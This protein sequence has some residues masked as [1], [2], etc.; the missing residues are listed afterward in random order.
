MKN[1]VLFFGPYP[2]PLFGQSISF[3][4]AYLNSIDA[5]ILFDTTK[6]GELKFLNTLYCIVF[7]PLIFFTRS[8]DKVYFTCSR[9]KLGFIKDLQL[10]VLSRLF[11]KK[12]INHLHGADFLEFYHSATYFKRLIYWAYNQIDTSIVLLPSMTDQFVDFKDMKI[13]VINNCYA[14]EY[15]DKKVDFKNKRNE[16]VFLSNLIFSKGIFIFLEAVREILKRDDEVIVKV[17]GSPMGDSLMSAHQLKTKFEKY[18]NELRNDFPNRFF[19][20]S[21]VRGRQKEE[22]LKQS[23]IFILPTFYK[24]E[25][26]PLT[27]IEAM[28]FG[29]AII[30][31][32]HNYLK[33]IVQEENGFLTQPKSV[34]ELIRATLYLLK[35]KN[36]CGKIQKKNHSEAKKKYNPNIFDHKLKKAISNT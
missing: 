22:L 26:F 12:V 8:F 29:N 36:I 15:L 30:T 13:V 32:N 5:K 33:D 18:A 17:A 20:L 28:Y 6:F 31:T 34:D 4:Q 21:I 10:L 9:S 27:I 14:T 35:N 24:T 1:K 25:A 11:N 7:L 2:D 16:I 3:K 23:S 19:Y